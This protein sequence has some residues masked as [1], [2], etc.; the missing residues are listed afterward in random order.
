MNS[1]RPLCEDQ[2][3]LLLT[4]SH[5]PRQANQLLY[6][7]FLRERKSPTFASYNSCASLFFSHQ[8]QILSTTKENT[9]QRYSIFR[10]WTH[11]NWLILHIL[12]TIAFLLKFETRH[13]ALVWHLLS[14]LSEA[15]LF[16]A[17]IVQWRGR[18]SKL[19]WPSWLAS[20]FEAAQKT[21]WQLLCIFK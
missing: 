2:H 7:L 12:F 15:I 14:H 8:L 6:I 16:R 1:R 13:S 21:I 19:G 11:R 9:L 17:H 18:I 10:Q 20:S 4:L 5:H 3:Y